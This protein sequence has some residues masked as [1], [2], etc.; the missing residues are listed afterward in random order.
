MKTHEF[1]FEI[2]E[3]QPG[4]L[5]E[6]DQLLLQ[7]A[8]VAAQ[9][10]YAP[11]SEFG[12]GAAV[13]LED[14]SIIIGNNQENAAYPSGMC[15][16]RVA[17]FHVG[18]VQSDKKIIAVAVRASSAKYKTDQPIAPCGGC[19]QVMLESEKR[20]GSPIKLLTAGSSGPVYQVK[21]I[22]NLLPFQF[23]LLKLKS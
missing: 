2:E 8:L 4:D 9:N 1:R 14:G 18:A 6:S 17:F 7:K 21:T 20:Q 5:P 15:A 16:E 11:Y 10:A 19:L 23:D 3:W 22:G 12:V 13:L